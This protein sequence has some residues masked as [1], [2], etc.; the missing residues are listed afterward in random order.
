MQEERQVVIETNGRGGTI[1][2]CEGPLRIR[3]DWELGGTCLALIWGDSL[4]KLRDS[5]SLNVDRAAEI[6]KFV[7]S[8]AVA[9]KATGYSFDLDEERCQI[10]I[11]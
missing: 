3:F 5:G 7:A 8:Q 4:R 11:G 6:L 2:Y 9:Q 10:T 1:W